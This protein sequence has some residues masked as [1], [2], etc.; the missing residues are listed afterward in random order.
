MTE[1]LPRF[2]RGTSELDHRPRLSSPGPDD[3]AHCYGLINNALFREPESWFPAASTAVSST[4]EASV[5]ARHCAGLGVFDGF[6]ARA[7]VHRC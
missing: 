5:F 6:P 4:T 2:G 3:R 1:D 7:A